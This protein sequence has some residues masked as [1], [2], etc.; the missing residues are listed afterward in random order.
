MEEF[1]MNAVRFVK[2]VDLVEG[3]YLLK[4]EIDPK[5]RR[6]A[7]V[8]AGNRLT[9]RERGIIGKMAGEFSL[10]PGCLDIRQ[11]V[12]LEDSESKGRKEADLKSRA[13]INRLNKILHDFELR[14][15]SLAGRAA[16]GRALLRE[17]AVFQPQ[18][19]A[20]SVSEA[21]VYDLKSEGPAK[22]TIVTLT[23]KGALSAVWEKKVA[24]W[25]AE[26]LGDGDLVVYYGR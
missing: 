7:L 10:D 23:V 8:Y 17:L 3:N 22:K 20:C 2:A 24:E 1:S 5:R 6:I 11:G 19:T 26:R 4:N 15:D 25:L 13:E 9:D 14:Q 21:L 12:S 18:I 16:L